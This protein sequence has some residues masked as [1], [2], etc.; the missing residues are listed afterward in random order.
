VG[1]IWKTLD[2]QN[3]DAPECCKQNLIRWTDGFLEDQNANR[4]MN[5]KNYTDEI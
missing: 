3:R 1:G 5:N 4:N 2:M